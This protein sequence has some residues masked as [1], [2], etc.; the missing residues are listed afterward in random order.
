MSLFEVANIAFNYG[1]LK[2][3]EDVSFIVDSAEKVALIGPNGAGKTTLLNV[4]T[5]LLYPLSGQIYF[6]GQDINRLSIRRR[7][8]MGIGRSF[9]IN[10]LFLDLTLLDNVLLALREVEASSFQMLRPIMSYKK[11]IAE[12]QELLESIDLWEKRNFSITSL[13]H[14]EQRY[15]EIILAMASQP[16]LLLLDEPSAG[17]TRDE[18]SKLTET[19]HGIMKD[20]AVVYISHDLDLVHELSDRVLFLYYGSI[21][22]EGT[23][24]EIQSNQRVREIYLGIENTDA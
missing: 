13:S 3:L 23:P 10:T 11:R 4:L 1:S 12:A 6:S 14:G 16:K 7:I 15:V 21:L 18:S 22:A 2:V 17:L 9:Q 19:L 5:G 20:T 8:S 24:E